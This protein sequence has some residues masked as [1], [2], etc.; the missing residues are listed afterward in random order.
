MTAI[1]CLKRSTQIPSPYSA[2]P[3]DLKAPVFQ[4]VSDVGRK[5]QDD[6]ELMLYITAQFQLSVH[7]M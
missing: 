3:A 4:L 6:I 1:P 7:D 5:S 2:F